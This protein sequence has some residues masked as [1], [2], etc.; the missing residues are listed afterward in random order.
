MSLSTVL[1]QRGITDSRVL[2]ALEA[3]PRERFVSE[4]LKA[5]AYADRALPIA[6]GQTISQPYMVA[7]MSQVL[8]LS[9]SE[10]V[11]EIGT[12]SGYQTAVMSQLAGDVVS[13]ERHPPL[14]QAAGA[15]LRELGCDNVRLVIGDGTLGEPASAPFDRIIVTAGAPE[16]PPALWEQLAEGGILVMPRGE[17]GEQTLEEI[18]KLGGRPQVTAHCRCRFVDLVGGEGREKGK[19]KEKDY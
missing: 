5:A 10:H 13:V 16:V 9:G 6:C 2:R 1:A 15:V 11:L 4:D 3:V 8:Q 14:S 17:P 7:L 12:G 18:R 19:G